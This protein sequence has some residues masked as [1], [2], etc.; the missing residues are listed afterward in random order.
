MENCCTWDLM[1][2]ELCQLESCSTLL[3]AVWS[4]SVVVNHIQII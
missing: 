2:F 4:F 1:L 3:N